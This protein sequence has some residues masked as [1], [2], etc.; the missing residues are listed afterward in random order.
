MSLTT[1][2]SPSWHLIL[3]SYGFDPI[4]SYAAGGVTPETQ[5]STLMVVFGAFAIGACDFETR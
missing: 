3:V 1:P 4:N 5:G 2:T